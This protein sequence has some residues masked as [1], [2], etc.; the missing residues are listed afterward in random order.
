MATKP[1]WRVAEELT[2]F[3]EAF[4]ARIKPGLI[5][6]VFFFLMCETLIKNVNTKAQRNSNT[7]F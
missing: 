7:V 1:E 6:S 3:R 4:Q 5:I 2:G